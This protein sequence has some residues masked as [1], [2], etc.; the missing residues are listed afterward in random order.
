MRVLTGLLAG[1]SK[2]A[3]RK[4]LK[5][6]VPNRCGA[7]SC[8]ADRSRWLKQD[9]EES[10][11]GHLGDLCMLLSVAFG[12]RKPPLSDTA[13]ESPWLPAC[14]DWQ[15]LSS[16]GAFPGPAEEAAQSLSLQLSATVADYWV[17]LKGQ[18]WTYDAAKRTWDRPTQPGSHRPARE[19]QAKT[20]PRQVAQQ[21]SRSKTGSSEGWEQPAATRYTYVL[22]RAE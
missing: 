6:W 14:T 17:L 11:V 19:V 18:D 13:G 7:A 5:S 22:D 4:A 2:E 16:Q 8:M 20:H 12:S 10:I 1:F 3:E 21:R 15:Q 9:K